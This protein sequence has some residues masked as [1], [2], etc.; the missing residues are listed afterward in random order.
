MKGI[1]PPRLRG[2]ATPPEEG[3]K[4]MKIIFDIEKINDKQT[5]LKDADGRLIN[6]PLDLLPPNS[7]AGDKINFNIGEEENQAKNILNEILG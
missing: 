3:T 6:W 2:A 1:D 4:N 7:K 5:V